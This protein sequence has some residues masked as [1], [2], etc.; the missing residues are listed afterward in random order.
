MRVAVRQ[1]GGLR[2]PPSW[3]GD[4][5]CRLLLEQ[6]ATATVVARL[7]LLLLLGLRR[8][9]AA[10]DGGRRGGGGGRL[11]ALG[12]TSHGAELKHRECKKYVL[13]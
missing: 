9:A 1:R 13:V 8:P 10:D 3:R 2:R 6:E 11:Q 7:L 12:A 4:D 5:N